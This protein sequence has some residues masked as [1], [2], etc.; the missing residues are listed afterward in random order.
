MRSAVVRTDRYS[1]G[2][3]AFHWI[4]AVAI[5]L[6]L[7][8]GIAHDSLPRDWR[9][10]P[11]HKAVGITVLMLSLARLAWRL[12]HR[13]PPLP[14]A[15]PHWEKL[16]AKAA[17]WTLYALT[18]VIPLTGW[19]MVSNGNP[20][21]PLDWFGLFP[22][23]YLPVSK[24]VS[25]VSHEAHEILGWA[26]L[27]LVVLHILAALRHHLIL[28]DSTLVRMLPILRAPTV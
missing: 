10:M 22:I 21:R 11:V 20:P 4:I 18:I 17:H 5:L 12:G 23:P 6:N 14:L 8:L 19:M 2:A 13:P 24:A 7:W 3:I 25:G 28:R 15:L 9:V 1:R 26:L 27:V 16:T